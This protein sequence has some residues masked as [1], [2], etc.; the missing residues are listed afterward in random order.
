MATSERPDD[1]RGTVG[2]DHPTVV[3]TNFEPE[4]RERDRE[5]E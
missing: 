4:P 2:M 5:Q 3:P 1:R